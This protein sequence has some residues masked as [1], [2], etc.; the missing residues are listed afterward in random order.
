MIW[1]EFHVSCQAVGSGRATCT[2][3]HLNCQVGLHLCEVKG[4]DV[5]MTRDVSVSNKKHVVARNCRQDQAWVLTVLFF[6]TGV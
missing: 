6:G 4:S 2:R 1:Y 3:Y 5:I